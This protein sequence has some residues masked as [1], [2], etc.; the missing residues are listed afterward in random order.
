MEGEDTKI[1]E[2]AHIQYRKLRDL[3]DYKELVQ[4]VL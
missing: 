1:H 2:I 3:D 4:M